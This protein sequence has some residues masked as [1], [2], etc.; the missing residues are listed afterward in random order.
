MKIRTILSGTAVVLLLASLS[1]C[2]WLLA[3]RLTD[4]Q[5]AAAFI[6]TANDPGRTA[7]ELRAHFHPDVPS[8]RTMNT[9]DFWDNTFFRS[10]GQPFA[11][12]GMVPGGELELVPLTTALSGTVTSVNTP[13]GVPITFGFL[14]DPEQPGNRLIA[15]IL[16]VGVDD[17][18]RTIR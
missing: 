14:P 6:E 5:R 12:E 9:R 16:V 10:D 3:E 18:I 11:L 2:D 4:A 13:G 1:A 17:P 8:Y 15:V 7:L